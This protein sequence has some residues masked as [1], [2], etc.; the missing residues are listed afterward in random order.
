MIP[1]VIINSGARKAYYKGDYETTY[2]SFY[3][4]K[5]LSD[6]DRILF[7]RSEI[8]LKMLHKYDAYK[9]YV[10]IDMAEEA[11]DQLLQAV[12]NYEPWL[13]AAEACGAT[14]EFKEAYSKCLNA[15]QI[16]YGM[17][18]EAAKEVIALPTDEEYSLMVHAI[19]T[20]TEYIDPT[21]PLPAP[22]V[23]PESEIIDEGDGFGDILDEEGN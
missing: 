7:T 11:L 22:F 6:S 3:G 13:Y 20:H 5:K 18:E 1:K 9:T 17:S 2:K 19:V 14:E 16:D 23:E 15:L 12:Q 10:K 4:E 21:A 8:V